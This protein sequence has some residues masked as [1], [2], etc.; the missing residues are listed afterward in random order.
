MNVLDQGKET[1][2]IKTEIGYDPNAP[3][4]MGPTTTIPFNPSIPIPANPI[5]S[6][7]YSPNNAANLLSVQAE[8]NTSQ[9][10]W[11]H[12]V[13][14]PL[15]QPVSF[16]EGDM[17]DLRYQPIFSIN[18]EKSPLPLINYRL[19]KYCVENAE[20]EWTFEKIYSLINVLGVQ[21]NSEESRY[22]DNNPYFMDSQLYSQG[23]YEPY[24]EGVWKNET[25]N[26]QGLSLVKNIWPGVLQPSMRVGF[27]MIKKQNFPSVYRFSK[28]ES[29]RHEF[30]KP[31]EDEY[32]KV[33]QLV[34]I[35]LYSNFRKKEILN[36][37]HKGDRFN[38]DF[39]KWAFFHLG[40]VKNEVDNGVRGAQYDIISTKHASLIHI[41][42][43]SYSVAYNSVN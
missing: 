6:L 19:M 31:A 26:Y 25:I 41:Y 34:P 39:D 10:N 18:N 28:N 36:M 22:E 35:C 4:N 43:N 38:Y 30:I 1:K 5:I 17:P 42:L 37:I 23:Q 20:S 29:K 33:W 13:K 32:K 24:P 3:P 14:T 12:A 9:K 2:R 8:P 11:V 16:Y 15:K 40:T 21:R 7:P 27:L